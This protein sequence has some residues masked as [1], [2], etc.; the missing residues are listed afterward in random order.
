VWEIPT[1][2]LPGY[3][4]GGFHIWPEGMPDPTGEH[5]HEQADLPLTVADLEEAIEPAYAGPVAACG[6]ALP[7]RR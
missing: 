1:E 2:T 4:R 6:L 7:G 3:N 5:L